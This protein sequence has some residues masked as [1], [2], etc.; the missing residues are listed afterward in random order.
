MLLTLIDVTYSVNS[1]I[2]ICLKLYQRVHKFSL[3]KLL[4]VFYHYCVIISN[5]I[6]LCIVFHTETKKAYIII[7]II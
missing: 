2:L 3:S 4:R 1:F 6:K 7:I 5:I